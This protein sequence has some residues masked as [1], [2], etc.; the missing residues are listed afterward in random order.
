LSALSYRAQSLFFLLGDLCSL[1]L[2]Q[3]RS[4]EN[5]TLTILY[6][7]ELDVALKAVHEAGSRVMEEYA[8]F[9]VIAN[10]PADIST[11]ADHLS[12]A[13]I[14]E[15]LHTAFPSDALC[16]EETMELL[17][18]VPQTGSRVWI[19]DPIDGTRGFA[20]KND[21]FSIMI[22]LVE[23]GQIALGVVS[24]PA[25]GRL[26]YATYGGGCWKRDGQATQPE[27][28]HV[29]AVDELTSATL[30]QSH[31]RNP[32][33]PSS[34]VRSVQPAKVL[35]TYSAGIKLAMVAR[36]DAD[37]YLNTY[38]EF[39]DWDICAGHILVSEAGGKVTGLGGQELHYGLPGAWQRHGVLATNGRVHQATLLALVTGPGTHQ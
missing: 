9:Q 19:V 2:K 6:Q 34:L 17:S 33:K 20:R 4:A 15:H 3:T 28:C 8:R 35:E 25:K 29:T 37:I 14:L 13:L 1:W 31:S 22:A 36:G 38:S 18:H 5:I 7:H 21:E 23:E 26:T 39:H 30:V 24:E 12:Q 11:Q 27:P 16:A 10:A 32:D